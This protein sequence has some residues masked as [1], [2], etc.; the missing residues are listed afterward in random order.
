M[1]RPSL[2]V[3]DLDV[4]LL[5]PLEI[6]PSGDLKQAR[7]DARN[8]PSTWLTR[9]AKAIETS[10]AQTRQ[11]WKHLEDPFTD[12]FGFPALY[13]D[14]TKRFA[15]FAYFHPFIQSVLYES[16]PRKR[17]MAV[18]ARNDIQQLALDLNDSTPLVADVRRAQMFLFVTDLAVVAVQ[19]HVPAARLG[20]APGAALRNAFNFADQVRRVYT[21]YWK[22]DQPGQTPLTASWR[23][24]ANNQIGRLGDYR[25]HS[26]SGDALRDHRLPLV[27]HWESLISPWRD[28]AV[29]PQPSLEF[30][31]LG[32]E[33]CHTM[34]YLSLDRPHDLPEFHHYRMAF[35]DEA[36]DGWAYQPQFLR[37]QAKD[38]FYDRFWCR[39]QGWMNT[40]YMTTG[41][42]F[43]LLRDGFPGAAYLHDHFQNHYFFLNLLALMQKSSMLIAWR[44]LSEILRT[45]ATAEQS[46]AERRDFHDAQKWLSED[47]ADYVALFEFSEVSNQLQALEL[48]AMIRKNLGCGKLFEE[49]IRQVEFARNVEQGN[50]EERM[51]AKAQ[52]L[53]TEQNRLSGIATNLVNEQTVLSRIAT[54]WIPVALTLAYLGMSVSTDDFTYW[55][56]HPHVGLLDPVRV[57]IA[58]VVP[59]AVWAVFFTLF[60][61]V[62]RVFIRP[63]PKAKSPEKARE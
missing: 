18:L 54:L 60:K 34:V 53:A 1:L 49:L 14:D 24:S 12:K 22:G 38:I 17:A 7:E 3:L 41:Y 13:S 62:E 26:Q 57:P 52:E 4:I 51:H 56:H 43:V 15:E 47:L 39:I 29:T 2:T 31:Q 6:K 46:E 55:L 32:D 63:R 58:V 30:R 9:Y 25:C 44:R 40:R 27:A 28:S 48:F 16:D 35:L 10:A 11:P 50:Y 59:V 36:D 21:P 8:S 45:Y 5:L 19:L 20:S 61:V 42:S 23:D 37:S 33:R